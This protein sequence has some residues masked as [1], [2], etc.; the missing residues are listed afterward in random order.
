MNAQLRALELLEQGD[1]Q[2]AH[3][4]AQ[5]DDS[6]AGCWLHGIVHILEGD[7]AN[8]RYWYNRA[9]R[10]WPREVD[11]KTELAALRTQLTES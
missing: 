1:W 7:L 4:I 3:K 2:Q 9:R 6:A 11:A 10:A 8:A 5:E